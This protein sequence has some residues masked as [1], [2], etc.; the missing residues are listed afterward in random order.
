M[1]MDE[2]LI[3]E[4]NFPKATGAIEKY[5]YI[6][7][8]PMA[9]SSCLGRFFFHWAYRIIA[10]SK[11]TLLKTEYLGN[12]SPNSRSKSF[13]NKIY[14]VWENKRYKAIKNYPLLWTSIRTNLASIITVFIFTLINSCLSVL[15]IHFFRVYISMFSDEKPVMKDHIY[16]GIA[17]LLVRLTDFLLQRKTTELLNYIGNKSSVE[18][19]CLIYDKLLKLSP[20]CEVKSGQIYNYLQNDSHK[21]YN[22]M[23]SCPNL[24]TVPFLITMY[25]YLLF[26]YMGIS[27][28]FGFGVMIVFLFLNYYFRKKFSFYLKLH[29][30]KSDQRMRIVTETFNNLKVIKLY[31][32]DDVFL[33]KIQKARDEELSALDKRYQITQVSQTLLWLAP[34]A[35]SVAAIGA[36]QYFN[37]SFKIEDMFTCLG[38]FTSIQNPMRMLPV[39]F[40]NIVETINSLSRIEKFLREPEINKNLMIK[41]DVKTM[42]ENIAIKIEGGNFTWGGNRDMKKPMK[43]SKVIVTSNLPK[44]E[45]DTKDHFVELINVT[46]K[47]TDS[48]NNAPLFEHDLIDDKST[49]SI[50]TTIENE[51]VLKDINFE[52]RQGEFVCV[53]G[54]VGSGKSSLLQAILNNMSSATPRHT[55]VI[56]NGSISYVSQESWIQNT[57]VQN[58][59]LFFH[60]FNVDKYNKILELC[61]LKQDLDVL[62]GG[63]L[64]EIGEKGVNLSGGQ[65]ARIS[66]ARAMYTDKDI[67]IL[68]DPISAL[69]AHV[70]KNIMMNCIVGYL[71]NKTRILVTHALQYAAFA[72]RIVYMQEGQIKWSGPYKELA[73]QPF[74]QTFLEKM[75]SYHDKKEKEKDKEKNEK[76]KDKDTISTKSSI[77]SGKN[78]NN[79]NQIKRITKDEGK[80]VGKINKKVFFAYFKYI[81]GFC[82]LFPLILSLFTWQFLKVGSDMWLGYWSEHQVKN[83]NMFFF[84]IYASMALGSTIFNYFRTYLITSGSLKCSVRLHKEM[85]K[86]L[87]DAPIN[88]FH[89]T[90]PKGQIFNR[91]SKD[92]P[93]VDTYT[94]FWFMTLSS[95][96]SSFLGAVI[97][98]S[99]Y[100]PYCLFILPF[101]ICICW[102]LS[103]FYM[104]CSR[105]LT[106]IE[107][108]L[109]SPI[110]NLINETIPGA[111]TIR[112]YNFEDIYTRNF[113]GRVDDHFKVSVFL[114]GTYQWYLLIL[115]ILS[116]LFLGFLIAFTLIYKTTF[117]PKEIG[118]LLTYSIVLNE[119]LVQ[120]LSAYSNF[121]NTMTKMERCLG[122]TKIISERPQ[123]TEIDKDNTNWPSQGKI[124]FIDYSVKYRP[125]TEIVL[126]N[127]SF[128]VNPGEHLGI[129]GRTGSGKSTISLCLFRILEAHSGKILIDDVDISKLGLKKLR[130]SI[131][132]I[133]QDATLM[134]GTLRYNIDPLGIS[135]TEEIVNVMKRIGFHYILENHP[136]GLEQNISENGG[137]LSIGEKQL[138]CIT[139]AILRKS[140]IVIMDEATASI[141]FKTEE[142]IQKAINELLRDST[143]IT[144]AHRIKTVVNSDKI[145]VLDNGT[146]IEYDTPQNLLDN[147]KSYFYDYYSKSLL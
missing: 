73:L 31:G 8:D 10:L 67:F 36:Y 38:I 118:I 47:P 101:F 128:T 3:E 80:E 143:L 42:K 69:D 92:L 79:N 144:I 17:Y 87:I 147:K 81:G 49:G 41:N 20:C 136:Q 30:K 6:N 66:L 61:E 90:T 75:N 45:K 9:E 51:L 97:M 34:I 72:D 140:K 28:V 52:V 25:N 91:L 22:L 141:D 21:L 110:L 18:L 19:N 94:M 117:T 70:G 123:E 2:K 12:L 64:T 4:F 120:F 99:I 37:D 62:V 46:L 54:E 104:N 127:L 44:K 111:T 139:R 58:N 129:V 76:T 29:F 5:G 43:D 40:D 7:K 86:N 65:K 1:S 119:D 146:I 115:N 103:R 98:C 142:I 55:K 124:Q 50:S 134:T 102:Y 100:Q 113:Q 89:D 137:N 57:T 130:N 32:W 63:D 78:N 59:I 26:Q 116:F 106:R 13:F 95:F 77:I 15:A 14:T 88:L 24:L 74:Y 93:T 39:T 27:F 133:P 138:I 56:V 121:E 131:T 83:K 96:G 11:R 109:N 48:K 23:S 82:M 112:A 53:I 85:I 107:G 84:S 132:I 122:Y 16:I 145:L 108:V 114:V 125:D 126:K 60:P 71:K 105:E 33:P 68:D 135:R 35:M